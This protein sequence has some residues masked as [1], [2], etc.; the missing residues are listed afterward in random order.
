MT[1]VPS[2]IPW[3]TC[4]ELRPLAGSLGAE[5]EG[6][7]LNSASDDEIAQFRTALPLAG[8]Q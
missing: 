7:D 5:I 1:S 2:P 8:T 3:F 6:I 4:F